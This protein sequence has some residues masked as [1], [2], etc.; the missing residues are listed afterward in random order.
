M[1]DSLCTV[2]VVSGYF[3]GF[4]GFVVGWRLLLVCELVY[5]G[6][7][8]VSWRY[9]GLVVRVSVCGWV[10][11]LRFPVLAVWAVALVLRFRVFG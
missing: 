11:V 2:V 3:G 9:V 5:M 1:F 10:L 7:W 8:R 4:C 6:W